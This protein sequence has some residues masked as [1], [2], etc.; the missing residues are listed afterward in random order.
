MRLVK[1]DFEELFHVEIEQR[2]LWCASVYWTVAPDRQSL[3]NKHSVTT[4]KLIT[5][6]VNLNV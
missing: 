3:M 6:D 4:G 2:W 5:E 1:G